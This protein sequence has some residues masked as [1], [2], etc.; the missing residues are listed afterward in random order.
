VSSRSSFDDDR[1][2]LAAHPGW[3]AS[4]LQRA[5]QVLVTGGLFVIPTIVSFAS[6][7]AFRPP[8]ELLF[9]AEAIA[10]LAIVLLMATG[11]A[12]RL[13][14]LSPLQLATLAGIVLW[15]LVTTATSPHRAISAESAWI[16]ICSIVILLATWLVPNRRPL[17]IALSLAAVANAV[18]FDFQALLGMSP[19]LIEAEGLSLRASGLLGNPNDI[20]TFMLFVALA[21]VAW[22]I[23]SSGRERAISI[24]FAAVSIFTIFASRTITALGALVVGL[25]FVAALASTNRRRLLAFTLAIAVAAVTFTALSPPLRSRARMITGLLRHGEINDAFTGRIV[26]FLSAWEMSRDH[27]VTGVGPGAFRSN[28]FDYK[29]RVDATYHDL[30]PQRYESW[31]LS[32]RISFGEAHNEFLQTAAETGIPGLVLMLIAIGLVASRSFGGRT[33]DQFSRLLAL[34][35]AASF[36]VSSLAQFPLRIAAPRLLVLTLVALVFRGA[37]RD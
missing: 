28:Y 26:P 2:S 8:K 16:V 1:A 11:R 30:L 37:D 6:D 15:T 17:L 31:S 23:C 35:L 3:P 25:W 7:E 24:A 9:R 19:F 14:R 21:Q 13:P 12:L 20:G 18:V 36:C 10:A 33:P 32:R 4:G 5:L 22:A 27:L 34:P 29:I